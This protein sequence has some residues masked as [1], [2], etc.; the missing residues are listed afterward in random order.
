M[1]RTSPARVSSPAC[2]LCLELCRSGD[3]LSIQHGL[4]LP[5]TVE[6]HSPSRR[7]GAGQLPAGADQSGARWRG[8][9]HAARAGRLPGLRFRQRQLQVL[10]CLLQ[11][12]VPDDPA[13]HRWSAAGLLAVYLVVFAS[14]LQVCHRDGCSN[15]GDAT[16]S[17]GISFILTTALCSC[18]A[19]VHRRAEGEVLCCAQGCAA[20]RRLRRC[21]EGAVQNA[22]LA[23]RPGRTHRHRR[24][25]VA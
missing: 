14:C 6:A 3:D 5:S 15:G 7:Q 23:G 21:R 4:H 22:W 19:A 24:V 8:R 17:Q 18:L 1:P 25:S 2:L 16:V 12:H 20:S 13:D 9:P 10:E 11:Q